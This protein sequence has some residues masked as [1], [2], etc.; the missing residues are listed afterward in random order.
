MYS[1]KLRKKEDELKKREADVKKKEE[2][3]KAREKTVSEREQVIA[4][5]RASTSTSVY[6]T[7]D[8]HLGSS[9]C[10][11]EAFSKLRTNLHSEVKT[12]AETTGKLLT[13]HQ[14]FKMMNVA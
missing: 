2:E 3:L 11:T 9:G 10:S 14:S 8:E 1:N 4:K 7:N 5:L 6:E 12:S 13:R